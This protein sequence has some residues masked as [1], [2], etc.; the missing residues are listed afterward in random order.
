MLA[1]WPIAG[2]LN[3]K[4]PHKYG[5]FI[6]TSKIVEDCILNMPSKTMRFCSTVKECIRKFALST[7]THTAF[8]VI[9]GP[10]H[11]IGQEAFHECWSD[12]QSEFTNAL[13]D[14]AIYFLFTRNYEKLLWHGIHAWN[15]VTAYITCCSNIRFICEMKPNFRMPLL[16]LLSSAVVE[17]GS[18][19]REWNT[20]I[21]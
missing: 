6:S 16:F 20:G 15:Y 9:K 14:R 4:Y 13:P 10:S 5:P 12:F 2:S 17:Q 19:T 8:N 1:Y 7:R 3:E 11:L 18:E 21:V